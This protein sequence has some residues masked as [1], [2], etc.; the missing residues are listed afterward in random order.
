MERKRGEME[1]RNVNMMWI[2]AVDRKTTTQQ[3]GSRLR[4]DGAVNAVNYL[5]LRAVASVFFFFTCLA[6]YI[7]K[8]FK[9]LVRK[10]TTL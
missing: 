6:Q 1:G 9:N 5:G 10:R 8:V 4:E 7:T 3:V 2:N